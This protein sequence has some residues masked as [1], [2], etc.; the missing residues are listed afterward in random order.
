MNKISHVNHGEMNL[1]HDGKIVIL[2]AHECEHE[3][4]I[5]F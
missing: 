3:C 2:G 5:M 4:G 1:S